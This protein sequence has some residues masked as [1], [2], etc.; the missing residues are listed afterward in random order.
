MMKPHLVLWML[1]NETG[2]LALVECLQVEG[3]VGAAELDLADEGIAKI[4]GR[5]INE[6]ELVTAV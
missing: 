3:N 1:P 2:N 5:N 6:P 4:E